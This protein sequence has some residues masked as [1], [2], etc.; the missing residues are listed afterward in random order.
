[1]NQRPM[2][3][4]PRPN[5]VA[6]FSLLAGLSPHELAS[7]LSE[8]RKVRVEAGQIV[9][10]QNEWT[11]QVYFVFSG[12]LLGQL[13]SENGRGISFTQISA[14][15]YFGE[16]AALDDS[17]RSITVSAIEKSQLGVMSGRDFRRWLTRVP[18]LPLALVSDLA[19]RNRQLTERIH[20][21][22]AHDVDK[23]VRSYLT[24]LALNS[25]ALNVGGVL[26]RS[27][28]HEEI[29]T[30]VGANREAVSRV[31]SRLA[32]EGILESGRRRIIIRN[33]DAMLAGI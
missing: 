12:R 7:F 19:V 21:L 16:L 6:H 23:R 13:N 33:V 28:S 26:E 10:I 31:I 5:P 1:M 22:V 25:G 30:F 20:G 29:A 24:R 2:I 32:C 11:N 27:P 18:A 8:L 17:P 4:A 15:N 14:G 3:A 9:I